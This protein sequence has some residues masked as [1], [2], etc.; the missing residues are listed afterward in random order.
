MD[1]KKLQN[2]SLAGTALLALVVV[3]IFTYVILSTWSELGPSQ[4]ASVSANGVGAIGTLF[5]AVATLWTVLHSTR[6]MEKQERESE[7]PL[8]RNEVVHLIQPAINSLRNNIDCLEDDFKIDWFYYDPTR[9]FSSALR[10]INVAGDPTPVLSTKDPHA[11]VR[12]EQE[13]PDLY[14]RLQK[15]DDMLQDLATKADQIGDKITPALQRFLAKHNLESEFEE[16]GDTRTLKSAIIKEIDQYGE[17]HEHYDIWNEY[18]DEFLDILHSN[19]EEEFEEFL[20]LEATYHNHCESLLEDL[21]GRKI[22]LQEEYGFIVE[23]ENDE[24]D[25]DS[26]IGGSVT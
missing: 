9:W 7:K 4:R 19:A 18:R 8:A 6:R 13:R 12:L 17:S 26:T 3:F 10:G 21:K 14:Q 5:L 23:E 1:W 22:E 15:H 16:E 2:I 11:L 20:A 25:L 24:L